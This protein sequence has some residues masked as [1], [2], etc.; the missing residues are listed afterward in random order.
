MT[1]RR[2]WRD[3]GSATI[4]AVI[5]APAFLL[6][7]GLIIGAGR[8][9]I[10]HQS[11]EAAAAEAARTAS[12]A[13]TAGQ[14]RADATSSAQHTLVN[15]GLQ[16]ATLTVAVDTTGF[17]TPVGTPARVTATVVCV[18]SLA[19]LSVPGMPGTLRVEATVGS[20]LDTYRGR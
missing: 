9:A 3:R 6:F 12:V 1:T 14:A 13:R 10:A 15:Q 19:D 16:C 5:V 20:P 11:V 8:V 4:E 18:V 17:A 2:A 7:V